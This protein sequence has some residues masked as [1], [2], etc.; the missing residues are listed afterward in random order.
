M[1]GETARNTQRDFVAA[2]AWSIMT[3]DHVGCRAHARPVD[4]HRSE[5]VPATA[6]LETHPL[7]RL[8]V[9]SLSLSLSASLVV[10]P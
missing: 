2:P 9:S 4:G 8:S 6:P 3:L 7:P 1:P 10:A 5:R